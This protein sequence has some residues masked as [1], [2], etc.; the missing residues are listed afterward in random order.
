MS[1]TNKSSIV[2]LIEELSAILEPE[3]LLKLQPSLLKAMDTHCREVLDFF[4]E[5]YIEG[6]FSKP[7]DT[8]ETMGEK[9]LKYYN[10]YYENDSSDHLDPHNSSS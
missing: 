9:A 6:H 2:T 1:N 5:G 10:E 8:I 4:N 3:L 7:S